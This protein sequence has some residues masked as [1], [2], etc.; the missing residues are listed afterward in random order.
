MYNNQPSLM[1]CL[2]KALAESIKKRLKPA[3]ENAALSAKKQD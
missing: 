2:V 1:R 3:S